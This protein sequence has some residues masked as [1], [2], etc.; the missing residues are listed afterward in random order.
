MLTFRHL[1]DTAS[2]DFRLVDTL[3]ESAFPWHEKREAAAKQLALDNPHYRLLACYDGRLFVGMIGAWRFHGYSYIEHL[4][5]NDQ[6]RG[7]GY[8]KRM[9]RQFLDANPLTVLEIDPLTTGIARRRLRF[10][11]Q[12]GFQRNPFTHH[13]PSYHA[14][15]ADH[16]LLV[17]SHPHPLDD[18]RY[19]QF[20]DDLCHVVMAGV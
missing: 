12:L 8:G 17:L 20:H 13:H 10:Y 1:T 3:Y 19:Q 14:G 18:A 4:A 15:V 5:V 16:L 6:L 9:L 7:A 11:Q 2:D